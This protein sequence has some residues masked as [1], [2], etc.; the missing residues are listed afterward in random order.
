MKNE[1]D[2]SPEIS[3]PE[4][5]PLQRKKRPV[6]RPRKIV[7]PPDESEYRPIPYR[8]SEWFLQTPSDNDNSEFERL[9]TEERRIL[10]GCIEPEWIIYLDS[11]VR[12]LARIYCREFTADG[13]LDFSRI[14]RPPLSHESSLTPGGRFKAEI[15][16]CRERIINGT[17][18]PE[19]RQP[20]ISKLRDYLSPL[21]WE[22][23]VERS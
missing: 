10:E 20:D 11:Q 23:L 21:L 17:V 15:L 5:E 13:L 19:G 14:A 4:L 6:G 22:L 9:L 8:D 12:E 18:T 1:K 2:V 7:P 16:L 3:E